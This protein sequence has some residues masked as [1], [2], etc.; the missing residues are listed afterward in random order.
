LAT[1]ASCR[2]ATTT[3]TRRRRE[4]LREKLKS[5]LAAVGRRRRE[6][7]ERS[8]ET[9]RV[10]GRMSLLDVKEKVKEEVVV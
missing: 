10:D 7:I 9:R 4:G 8:H 5:W 6:G 3:T 2:R 1:P